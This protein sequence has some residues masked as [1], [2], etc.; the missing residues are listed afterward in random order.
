[1]S[2]RKIAL[3]GGPKV[4]NEGFPMWPAFE[5]ST[6]QKAMEPLRSG[7]VNYWTGPVGQEFEK[8]WAAWNGSKHAISVT[9]GTAALHVALAAMGI[10]PGDEVICPS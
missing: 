7:K 10:G 9:S 6:I 1:M 5:E 8:A 2:D 3:E 4:W